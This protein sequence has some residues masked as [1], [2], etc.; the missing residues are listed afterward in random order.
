MLLNLTPAGGGTVR[1]RAVQIPTSV[2]LPSLMT[3]PISPAVPLEKVDCGME[4]DDGMGGVYHPPPAPRHAADPVQRGRV[5]GTPGYVPID[6]RAASSWPTADCSVLECALLTDVLGE[7]RYLTGRMRQNAETQKVC[8]EWKFAAMVV[9]RLCLWLFSVFSVFCTG[10][11]LLST[12]E[13][14]NIF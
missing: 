9:D 8:S 1:P 14:R 10:T 7:V 12:P 2:E 11:I 5:N 3:T 6:G 4:A 13:V